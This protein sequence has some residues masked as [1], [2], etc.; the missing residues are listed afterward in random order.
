MLR[1]ATLLWFAVAIAV[2]LVLYNVKHEVQGLER[3]L[4]ELNR[5]I[6]TTRERIHVL[7]AEWS[8][9]NEPERLRA[10]ASRHL[11]LEPMRPAQ[12]VDQAVIAS[13]PAALPR[14]GEAEV[15]ASPGSGRAAQ[16]AAPAATP[17]PAPRPAEARREAQPGTQP[18]SRLAP[19][20][21]EPLPRPREA[22]PAPRRD[23]EAG[24]PRPLL[25]GTSPP[26]AAR[27]PT[28][29]IPVAAPPT[30]PPPRASHS[31]LGA[32]APALPPPVPIRR[33]ADAN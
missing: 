14:S 22:A 25:P 19:P 9:L 2:G 33:G 7:E 13:L 31:A 27:P 23:L 32:P 4:V 6:A 30:A 16:A 10:L 12:F 3:R 17:V 11:E 8:L 21:E 24:A 15:A 26:P 18:P 5:A 28:P 29:V 20:R 1:P